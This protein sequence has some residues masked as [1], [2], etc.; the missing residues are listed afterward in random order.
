MLPCRK[1]P[2]KKSMLRILPILTA[3]EIFASFLITYI[4]G[5]IKKDVD[6]FLPYISYTSV[7]EPQK[8]VFSQ[9]LNIGALLLG[10]NAYIRFLQVKACYENLSA[11]ENRLNKAGLVLG[12]ISAFGLSMVGNF[13]ARYAKVPHYFGAFLAFAIGSAYCWVQNFLTGKD[14]SVCIKRVRFVVSV[15]VS[16]LLVTCILITIINQKNCFSYFF[17]SIIK[18][19]LLSNPLAFKQAISTI[20]NQNILLALCAI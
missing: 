20:T 17:Y 2:R 1:A 19:F 15:L 8:S 3:A 4:I 5:V 10:F 9:S 16:I 11:N 18:N 14:T 13:H 7:D 12:L 6:V